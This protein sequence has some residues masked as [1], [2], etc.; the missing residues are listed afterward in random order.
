MRPRSLSLLFIE[1]ESTAEEE[2]LKLQPLNRGYSFLTAYK[3]FIAFLVT[4]D[5]LKL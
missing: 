4:N 5:I 3:E 2:C 1:T